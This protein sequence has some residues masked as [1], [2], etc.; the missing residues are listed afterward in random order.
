MSSAN[1]LKLPEIRLLTPEE[2][3]TLLI[4]PKTSLNRCLVRIG[5]NGR[6]N[7]APRSMKKSRSNKDQAGR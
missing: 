1:K 5:K 4:W 7:A 6:N 3:R 2:I